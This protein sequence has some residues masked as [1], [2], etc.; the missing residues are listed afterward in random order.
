MVIWMLSLGIYYILGK[1][2]SKQKPYENFND[3]IWAEK[4]FQYLWIGRRQ[5]ID[6]RVC[7]HRQC[8]RLEFNGI[9]IGRHPGASRSV[10]RVSDIFCNFCDSNELKCQ[11]GPKIQTIILKMRWKIIFQQL[12]NLNVDLFTCFL[13]LNAINWLV[14]IR[15]A[16]LGRFAFERYVPG[17][18]CLFAIR[19]WSIF[20]WKFLTQKK[21]RESMHEAAAWVFIRV[22]DILIILVV[23]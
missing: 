16:W 2:E 12:Q 15:R 6:E 1:S 17:V 11:V 3:S 18:F 5:T 19:V 13:F 14:F 22:L 4:T 20:F 21:S 23:F 7:I 8:H 9:V 10:G